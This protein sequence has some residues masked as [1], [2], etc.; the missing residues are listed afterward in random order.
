MITSPTAM[1]ALAVW[2]REFAET[3]ENPTIWESRLHTAKDLEEMARRADRRP[4]MV[5]RDQP[6]HMCTCRR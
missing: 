6:S 3:T 4:L 1:R 5:S 2:Y